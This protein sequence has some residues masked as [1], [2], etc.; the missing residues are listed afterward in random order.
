MLSF[1]VVRTPITY[2]QIFNSSILQEF[3]GNVDRDLERIHYL[4]KPFV[5][6]YI[7]FHPIDWFKK[8][9]MRAGLI[10]CPYKGRFLPPNC[11]V[12]VLTFVGILG[13]CTGEF[14]S[15]NDFTPCGRYS[16]VFLIVHSMNIY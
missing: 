11:F 12:K 5:A 16:V 1:H 15:I 4:N 2:R 10:G 8:I 9:S 3:G 13:P 6:R 14:M 7:R